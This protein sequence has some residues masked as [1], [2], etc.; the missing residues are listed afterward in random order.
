MEIIIKQEIE[1]SRID[2]LL[3]GAFEGGSNYW[4]LI[5]SDLDGFAGEQWRKG[6]GVKIVDIEDQE[7][8]VYTLNRESVKKGLMLL[9]KEWP[10][11]WNDFITENYDAYT[12]DAF[13]QLCLF[14][15]V[16]F[17]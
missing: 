14:D 9:H 5:V 12:S 15:G 7:G 11:H 1:D 8:P 17:G 10:T 4:Y 16:I 6:E 13:L 2:D 3:T